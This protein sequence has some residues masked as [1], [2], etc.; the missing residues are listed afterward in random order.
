MVGHRGVDPLT[1]FE[2]RSHQMTGVGAVD[3][4]TRGTAGL[5]PITARFEHDAVG[6]SGTRED[7][8][9]ASV[10]GI[11]GH[12]TSFE[13]HRV[14]APPAVISLAQKR[15]DLTGHAPANESV[16]DVWICV[17]VRHPAVRM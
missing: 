6:Q 14:S 3:G 10:G 17:H 5:P 2:A 8:V 7:D 15:L 11:D 1:P 9:S 4:G 12:S 13:A 16:H